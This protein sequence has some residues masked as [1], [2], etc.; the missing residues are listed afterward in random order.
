MRAATERNTRTLSCTLSSW[1]AIS[2]TCIAEGLLL[3]GWLT[4]LTGWLT[5]QTNRDS[6]GGQVRATAGHGLRSAARTWLA[7][8]AK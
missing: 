1:P 5:S 7:L 6:R 4:S 8:R 2:T 3:A